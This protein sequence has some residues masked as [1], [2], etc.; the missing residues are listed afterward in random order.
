MPIDEALEAYLASLDQA[1]DDFLNDIEQLE[2]DGLSAEEILL[3]IAALDISTYFIEDLQ[4]S[5]GISAY[6]AASDTILDNLPF[7]GATTEAKLVALRNIQQTMVLNLTNNIASNVQVT[8][9]QGV[10]NNLSKNEMKALMTSMIGSNRP[11]AVITT[12]LATYEQSVIA[13]MAEDLPE[14]TLW[15]YIGPRDEKNR[16]VCRQY[17]NQSPLTK[18]EITSIKSD[19]FIFRGGWRCRHQWG[20][21]D[22]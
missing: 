12:M 13:T 22:G 3:F 7:F 8:I 1:Q 14:N 4:L 9:A 5:Q 18:N 16:A 10:A 17:L 2:Q 15:E 21:V 11:D 20:V 6:M 19:G